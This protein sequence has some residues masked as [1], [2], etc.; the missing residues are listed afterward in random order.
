[1][2]NPLNRSETKILVIEDHGAF[3]EVLVQVLELNYSGVMSA[4]MGAQGLELAQKVA[5]DVIILDVMM[6]VMDGFE[7]CRRLRE[8]PGLAETGIIML[9]ASSDVDL[10]Y[11]ARD[12]GADLCL[13]KPCSIKDLDAAIERLLNRSANTSAA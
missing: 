1:M 7:T 9:T 5:P 6:P 12:A 3:R 2:E 4:A 11:K 13:S 8:I 10:L